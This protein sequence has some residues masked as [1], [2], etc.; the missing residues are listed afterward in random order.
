[1]LQQQTRIRLAIVIFTTKQI[2]EVG[3]PLVSHLQVTY[4]GRC[5]LQRWKR[6]LGCSEQKKEECSTRV[7]KCMCVTTKG[8]AA[9]TSNRM[10]GWAYLR[11]H[12]VQQIQDYVN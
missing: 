3:Q 10:R 11:S 8:Y 2:C 5:R 6:E 4:G 12:L 1:M 9:P 7:P